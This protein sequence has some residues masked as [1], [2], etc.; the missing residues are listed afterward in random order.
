MLEDPD[1]QAWLEHSES[2]VKTYAA[3]KVG[4]IIIIVYVFY[5]LY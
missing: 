2:W 3:F 5:Y 1:F 4:S